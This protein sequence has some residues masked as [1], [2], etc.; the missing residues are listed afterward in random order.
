M[1]ETPRLR[2]IS[3][4]PDFLRASL[5]NDLATAEEILGAQLPRDWPKPRHVLEMRL[6]QLE[7][8]PELEPWLTRALVLEAE[9]RVVG[10]GGFHGPPGGDWLHEFAPHGV[11][12]GYTVFE[13]H[14]RRGFAYES[15]VAL[16][17]WAVSEHGVA[18]FVLSI[19]PGNEAS[20]GVAAK[21]GFRRVGE[22]QHEERGPEHVYRRA[23]EAGSS[24]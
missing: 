8:K 23:V 14:R 5:S 15:S 13:E 18:Q 7:T 24:L 17:E 16:M 12:F 10:V 11:E 21:L 2:L 1:L 4:G 19:S 22:W 6:A 20:I 3:M 9:R